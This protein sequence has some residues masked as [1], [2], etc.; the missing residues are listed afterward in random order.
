M[1]PQ[2][3]TVWYGRL[4]LVRPIPITQMNMRIECVDTAPLGP[5][6]MMIS[7]NLI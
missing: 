5:D 2:S 3:T 6:K 1:V 4:T 7:R